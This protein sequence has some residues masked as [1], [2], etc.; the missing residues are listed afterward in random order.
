MASEAL[1]TWSA[2]QLKSEK[3]PQATGRCMR[4]PER[5]SR[6]FSGRFALFGGDCRRVWSR[7]RT[8]WCV[9]RGRAAKAFRV[10]WEKMLLGRRSSCRLWIWERKMTVSS[11]RVTHCGFGCLV[12]EA[13]PKGMLFIPK[14][15]A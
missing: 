5:D 1:S 8:C 13:M 15:E 7:E 4:T 9:E 10:G 6:A 14:W 12:E 3:S 11:K 2:E